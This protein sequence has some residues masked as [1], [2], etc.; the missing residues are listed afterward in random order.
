MC[1]R[2]GEEIPETGAIEDPQRT[3][4]EWLT[5]EEEGHKG[6]FTPQVAI[7]IKIVKHLRFSILRF[8]RQQLIKKS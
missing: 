6:H 1:W 4:C 2:W 3:R 8:F 7:I 5:D